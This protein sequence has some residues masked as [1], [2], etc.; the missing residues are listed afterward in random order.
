MNLCTNAI[1]AMGQRGRLCVSVAAAEVASE[2][3]FAPATLAPGAYVLLRVEDTGKGMDAQTLARIFEPFFTTKE[4]GKGTGL[5]LPL[6]C[7]IVTDAGGAID[8]RSTPGRGSTFSIYLP[9]AD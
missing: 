7:G 8:V 5:G 1:H 6:V 9:R 3:R 4:V 2:R